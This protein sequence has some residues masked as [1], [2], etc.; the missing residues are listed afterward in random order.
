MLMCVLLATAAC[1]KAGV[2]GQQVYRTY[3]GF[4]DDSSVSDEVRIQKTREYLQSLSREEFLE[5]IRE[6]V[7]QARI[8]DREAAAAR[9]W[10]EVIEKLKTAG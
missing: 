5:S 3:R 9:G 10:E 6:L 2:D 4:L 7:R 8:D 1:A